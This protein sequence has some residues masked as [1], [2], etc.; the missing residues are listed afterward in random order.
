[1]AHRAPHRTALTF[2]LRGALRSADPTSVEAA[3]DVSES[4]DRI[5]ALLQA[6]GDLAGAQQRFEE[7]HTIAL[8]LH[9]QDPTSVPLVLE[10]AAS[11]DRLGGLRQAQG[12]L[13]GALRHL[14]EGLALRSALATDQELTVALLRELA[15]SHDRVGDLKR[16]QG[17]WKGAREHYEARLSHCEVLLERKP[18]AVTEGRQLA[19]TLDELGD[20]LLAEGDVV[21]AQQRYHD[22]LVLRLRNQQNAPNSVFVQR[23]VWVSKAKLA[24]LPTATIRW[25]TVVADMEAMQADGT[26][27]PAD[28]PALKEARAKAAAE[29]ARRGD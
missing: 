28:Q 10:R 18:K 24:G 21:G 6:Q 27:S 7:R 26:L 17:D 3:R 5:G 19:L 25:S 14:E 12:D 4:L 13:P 8:G 23:D 29:K 22:S 20:V 1:M 2:A 16:A 11:L 15:A 9:A